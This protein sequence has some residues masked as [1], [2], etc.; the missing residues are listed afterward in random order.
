MPPT[1]CPDC[2]GELVEATAGTGTTEL[3][4]RPVTDEDGRFLGMGDWQTTTAKLCT[5]CGRVLLYADD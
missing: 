1:Q 4:V 5:E 2:R 3:V